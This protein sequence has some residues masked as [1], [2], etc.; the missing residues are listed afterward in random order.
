MNTNMRCFV[1]MHMVSMPPIYSAAGL[2]KC[3]S[4]RIEKIPFKP[5]P[6]FQARWDHY[7]KGWYLVKLP[8]KKLLVQ[9]Q[10]FGANANSDDSPAL[11]TTMMM[12]TVV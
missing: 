2:L 3:L 1:I 12:L 6:V 7:C 9:M 11:T 10:I 8:P 5:P 4:Q